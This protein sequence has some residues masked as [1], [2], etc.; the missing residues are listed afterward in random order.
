MAISFDLVF[1]LRKYAKEIIRNVSNAFWYKGKSIL[2]ME[3]VKFCY[4]FKI[5]LIQY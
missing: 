2:N 5:I 3:A 4:R 1:C